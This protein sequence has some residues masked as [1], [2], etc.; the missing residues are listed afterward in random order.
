MMKNK[1]AFGRALKRVR[2]ELALTQLELGER[3]G[4]HWTAIS[5]LETGKTGPTFKTVVQLAEG[6]DIPLGKLFSYMD[7]ELVHLKD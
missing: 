6:L 5:R 3:C 4:R 1:L 2:D 7:E